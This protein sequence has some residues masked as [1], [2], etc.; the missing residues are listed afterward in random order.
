MVLNQNHKF[1]PLKSNKCKIKLKKFLLFKSSCAAG[2]CRFARRHGSAGKQILGRCQ[3]ALPVHL[4]L[5]ALP[6]DPAVIL[7]ADLLLKDAQEPRQKRPAQVS[8]ESVCIPPM[9]S[10]VKAVLGSSRRQIWERNLR[11]MQSQAWQRRSEGRHVPGSCWAGVGAGR[12]APQASLG[13]RVWVRRQHHTQETSK[14]D[15]R[16]LVGFLSHGPLFQC[17]LKHCPESAQFNKN[18]TFFFFFSF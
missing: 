13:L 18:D 6:M 2:E 7:T 5:L 3:V 8:E 16:D 12:L 4:A 11:I 1:F 14:P 17:L 10:A 15:V 9:T